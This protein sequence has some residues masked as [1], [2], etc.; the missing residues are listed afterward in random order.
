MLQSLE[1][2]KINCELHDYIAEPPTLALLEEFLS[3]SGL[4]PSLIV[5]KSEPLYSKKYAGKKYSEKKWLE[6]LQKNPILIQRPLVIKG[7]KAWV[8]R[9]EETINTLINSK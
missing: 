5:R 4:L 8:A 6:I 9:D 2:N 7:N 1:A 3:K